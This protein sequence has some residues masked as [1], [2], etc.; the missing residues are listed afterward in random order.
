MNCRCDAFAPTSDMLTADQARDALVASVT[1]VTECEEVPL[2]K[3]S[4]RVLAAN[5]IAARSVPPH[6]NSAMDGYAVFA[7]DL[8]AA[9]AAGSGGT[10]RLPVT[11][12]I[13]AG[14]V[15]ERPARRGE[16]LR[17]F[18][19]APVPS[20][21]DTIIPQ[22]VCR[23]ENGHV[24]LPAISKGANFR[25]AGEDIATGAVVLRAGIRLQPQHI[26]LAASIGLDRL[27]VIRPLRVALLSTGSE[28]REP[29]QTAGPGAIY[30]SNRYVLAGLLR[31]LGCTVG[32]FGIVPDHPEK[33]TTILI[34]AAAEHD[35]VMASGGVSVGE[36]DHVKTAVSAL[37]ALHFWRIAIRPGRPLAFGRIGTVPFIGLPG[38]PVA[39]MVTF[40]MFARPLLL[41]MA[42]ATVRPPLA[43]PVLA[44]FDEIKRPGRREWMRATL[45]R[46]PDGSVTALRFP[47]EGSGILTSMTNSDGLID[48]PESVERVVCGDIVNFLP[49]S[50]LLD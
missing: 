5:L 40:L 3:A 38:N 11:G 44:G 32:D 22:E 4:G 12:R 29:G 1:P 8:L 31:R 7:C 6:D 34:A 25:H 20:G 36:E 47:F 16:A 10:I 30:D 18:T 21:P 24:T 37:G 17:I 46:N 42:G 15:L 49:F 19:G 26:G 35:L 23:E 2:I 39:S 33:L 50:E 41:T 28:L 14:Q 13:K 27:A 45:R 43:F 48:L 9:G